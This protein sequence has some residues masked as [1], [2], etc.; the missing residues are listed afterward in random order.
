MAT[1]RGAEFIAEQLESIA[2]QSRL[3]D[4]LVVS[5]DCS[6]DSTVEIIE[7][8]ASRAPFPVHIHR[9]EK[10]LGFSRNFARALQETKGE[11]IFVADQDDIWL[12]QKIERVVTD[13][14]RSTGY[15]ALIHDEQILD[16][17]T[18]TLF[19]RTYFDNQRALDFNDREL[20]SGNCTAL[21]RELLDI[22]TPFPERIN[23]DYWIGWMADAL[24]CRTVLREPLQL[25]RRHGANA[26]EPVMSERRPTPWS[27]LMRTGL[28]D[29]RPAWRETAGHYALIAERIEERAEVVDALLGAG[30]AKVAIE[31]LEHERSLLQRRIEMMSRPPFRRRMEVLRSWRCGFYNEFSGIKSAMKDL[32][33]P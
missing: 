25:Y 12:A 33:Q 5:D 28:P 17:R 21:R 4:E 30:R 19:E 11:L 8:F 18:G 20:V 24:G 15:L 22:L 7:Q 32:L 10:N 27:V 14:E 1:Y 2:E 13:M 29:P 31:K 9:N 26:S 3:P 16:Q 6:A 23:Y